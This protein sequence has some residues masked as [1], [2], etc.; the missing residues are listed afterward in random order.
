MSSSLARRT[1][2][3]LPAILAGAGRAAPALAQVSISI[4]PPFI[5]KLAVPGTR[6]RDAVSYV[7]QSAESMLVSLE[8]ADFDVDPEG[9]AIELPPG[10]QPSTLASSMRVTPSSVRVAPGQQ[11]FF[12]YAAEAPAAMDRP[13]RIMLFFV[14][15]PEVP[16]GGNRVVMIPRMGIPFYL[17]NGKGRPAS[18]KADEVVWERSGERGELLH[19]RLTAH[20][21]GD[22]NLRPGG[23]VHVRSAEG[24]FD[25]SFDFNEGREPILPGHERRWDLSFGPVPSEELLVTLR[26]AT[27]ARETYSSQTRVPAA[28]R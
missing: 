10:T 1:L 23:F 8:F 13:R 16:E 3:L 26:F 19:L 6:I 17:E 28:P 9:R 20:N 2:F 18:V 15:R 27:S 25:R 7:N 14:S 22:R 4:V 11:V 21:E 24:R 12:R 5:E